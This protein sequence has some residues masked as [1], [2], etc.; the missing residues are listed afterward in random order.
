MTDVTTTHT[1]RALIDGLLEQLLT[2]QDREERQ[3]ELAAT[4]AVLTAAAA[5]LAGGWIAA[6]GG[7]VCLALLLW[8]LRLF[9]GPEQYTRLLAWGEHAAQTIDRLEVSTDSLRAV[10]EE[11]DAA[12][13]PPRQVLFPALPL[14]AFP[15]LGLIGLPP[16]LAAA[17]CVLYG[18][19]VIFTGRMS[20]RYMRATLRR[21]AI[22]NAVSRRGDRPD[23]QVPAGTDAPQYLH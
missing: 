14:A 23:W 9:S 11:L 1:E 20:N 4:L 13:R 5:T 2:F 16:A 8:T 7:P 3:Q 17:A 12:D 10:Q 6:A 22:R 21:Y 18:M 19:G 15:L